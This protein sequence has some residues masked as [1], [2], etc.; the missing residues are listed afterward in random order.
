MI[1]T[2]MM[3]VK[4]IIYL[5]RKKYNYR[6]TISKMMIILIIFWFRILKILMRK[7]YKQAKIKGKKQTSKF[8][9]ILMIYKRPH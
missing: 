2:I 6:R 4:I 8:S 3:I 1:I 7:I 9:K 5:K